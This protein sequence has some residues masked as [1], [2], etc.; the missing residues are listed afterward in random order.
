[1]STNIS[2]SVIFD[3]AKQKPRQWVIKVG[4]ERRVEKAPNGMVERWV[5]GQG[6]VVFA[7]LLQPASLRRDPTIVDAE[8]SKLL[9][10]GWIPHAR[11]PVRLGYFEPHDFP[12][13][14]RDACATGTYGANN[15]CCHVT[16]VIGTRQ[17]EQSAKMLQLEKIFFAERDRREEREKQQL[18]QQQKLHEALVEVVKAKV[19]SDDKP[20]KRKDG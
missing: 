18:E 1:V 8:R 15:P 14:M 13:T 3:A 16:Y 4:T 6:N 17:A 12:E 11:C 10:K 7:Q 19:A 5:D 2:K 20:P 9:R